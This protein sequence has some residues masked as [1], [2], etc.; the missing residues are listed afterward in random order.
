MPNR[1]SYLRIIT[2][3]LSRTTS[4]SFSDTIIIPSLPTTTQTACIIFDLSNAESA[5][6][7]I[8]SAVAQTSFHFPAI[9]FERKNWDFH[10]LFLA[11][12]SASGKMPWQSHTGG[13]GQPNGHPAYISV[14]TRNPYASH[15]PPPPSYVP[16]PF[17][18]HSHV[19][20]PP[21]PRVIASPSPSSTEPK[22]AV[23]WPPAVREY[24]NR[25]F[26]ES[27][28]IP[29]MSVQRWRKGYEKSLLAQ[30]KITC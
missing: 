16:Q 15:L 1:L 23:V 9:Q 19:P 14:P 3:Q 4:H 27:S 24:V 7:Y 6:R 18:H 13:F 22:K 25:C 29:G 11:M 5:S 20:P 8:S 28:Q 26:A 12:Y 21:P 2:C 17:N 10:L 30:L